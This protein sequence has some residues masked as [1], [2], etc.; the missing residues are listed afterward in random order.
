MFHSSV[1][2]L[3]ENLVRKLVIKNKSILKE[4][5]TKIWK[6][7]FFFKRSTEAK[8]KWSQEMNIDCMSEIIE[9]IHQ[10]LKYNSDWERRIAILLHRI[11]ADRIAYKNGS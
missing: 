6:M 4:R 2:S 7:P 10:I 3:I 11:D 5:K 8:G 1:C 9:N